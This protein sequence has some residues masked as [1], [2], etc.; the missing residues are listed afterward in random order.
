MKKSAVAILITGL[1]A[2]VLAVVT[3][4]IAILLLIGPSAK[5]VGEFDFKKCVS[6]VT[7]WFD[8]T[9]I[10]DDNVKVKVKVN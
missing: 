6:D 4:I 8:D 3:G 10:P 9:F 7:E 1:S 2:L 5:K